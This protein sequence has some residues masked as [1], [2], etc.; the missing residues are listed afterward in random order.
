MIDWKE[1]TVGDL[2]KN[3]VIY[4]PLDG[5][6]GNIHP[7]Y[8][9]FVTAGI[10][11]I[12]ATDVVNSAIDMHT[13]K[14]ITF[15]QANKLQKG[16][17]IE[18]DVL[19]T[20]KAT[21]GR[22]AIV[23]KLET[24][25]IILTPQVTYYRIKDTTKLNN[26]FLK[27]YFDTPY[28]QDTLQVHGSSGSTRDYVGIIAQNELPILMPP[29]IDQEA[30][31]EVLSSIDDK[32]D[33]L[34]RNNKTLE[35]LSETTFRKFTSKYA[36]NPETILG[37]YVKVQGG[38]AFKSAD[39]RDEGHIGVLK[40]TNISFDSV[41]IIN[42]QY[43]DVETANKT[44]E[45]FIAK[46]GSF[47]ISM[48]GAEI[49]K[50][51]MVGETNRLLY[52]NQRVGMLKD[53]FENSSLLGYLFLKSTEGQ[54]H[55]RNTASGSAQENISSA[56][57]EQMIIPFIPQLEVENFT[58]HVS[59]MFENI[60]QNLYQIEQLENLRNILLPKLMSGAVRVNL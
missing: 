30:I 7:K 47:L 12:T 3:G 42:T 6:H 17:A 37:K 46:K 32:I 13:C 48:T 59:T 41:D 26:K 16:F 4:K 52:V 2:V 18:G 35:T 58:Y 5:N 53:I 25:Y 40:I 44:P 60:A 29:L 28:F 1:Y 49:G 22:T 14:F 19:L 10:P 36:E 56:G 38:C 57:I 39:F 45:R 55:I 23:K 51:G 15:E 43:I 9:D 31:A 21:L 34:N 50:I 8:N 24:P 33:L 27:Y 11:F 54:D 20:H